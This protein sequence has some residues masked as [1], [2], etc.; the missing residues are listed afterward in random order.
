MRPNRPGQLFVEDLEKLDSGTNLV[1]R[2]VD[3]VPLM[4]LFICLYE[5]CNGVWAHVWHKDQKREFS[6]F[7]FGAMSNQNGIWERDA[8]IELAQP[9][10]NIRWQ[11]FGF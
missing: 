11:E 1:L 4:C 6:C 8:W 2:A 3:F 10:A 5:G 7:H 9:I